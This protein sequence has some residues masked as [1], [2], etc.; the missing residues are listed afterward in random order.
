MG[1]P[2]DEVMEA[3]RETSTSAEAFDFLSQMQQRAELVLAEALRYHACPRAPS[4]RGELESLSERRGCE[5]VWNAS[6]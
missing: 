3:L 2:P 5:A 4:R 6:N 1:Y